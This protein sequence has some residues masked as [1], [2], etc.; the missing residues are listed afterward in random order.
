MKLIV[1]KDKTKNAQM[2]QYQLSTDFIVYR[3]HFVLLPMKQ[4]YT[5][6]QM[7]WI[8]AIIGN[9][10]HFNNERKSNA[11]LLQHFPK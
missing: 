10:T 9:Y 3:K 6:V 1:Q 5:I 2:Y 4:L 11:V 7:K 8:L